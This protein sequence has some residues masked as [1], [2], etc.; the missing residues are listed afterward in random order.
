MTTTQRAPEQ[1][2]IGGDLADAAAGETLDILNPATGEVITTTPAGGAEDVDR[3]VRAARRAF[4]EGAWPRMERSKRARALHRLSP[5]ASARFLAVNC[6]AIPLDL[7]ENQL[8]G[9]RKGA[10]TGADRDQ[11]G[12]LIHAGV[13]TVLLDEVGELPLPTQAKML[14]ALEQKEVLPVG[15]NEPVRFEARIL[16]ATN[17]NLAKEV[18]VGRFREDLYYRLNIVTIPLPPG[19]SDEAF[20]EAWTRVEEYVEA[21]R[22]EFILLQCGADSVDG[23][24]LTHMQFTPAVHKF[25]AGR[26][27]AIADRL[28]HGRVVAMGGGGYNRRNLARAWAGVVEALL[29]P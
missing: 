25:A 10:F 1:M 22:P 24:P 16:A 14:R 5:N 17:K 23:D 29:D 9:H 27:C 13:G 8:F 20:H 19:A 4:E 18:E 12:V 6:A 15:A 26:L 28:G 11:A 3:A 21:G 7:L 2:L